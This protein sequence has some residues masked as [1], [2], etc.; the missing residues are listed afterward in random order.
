MPAISLPTGIGNAVCGVV[1][2]GHSSALGVGLK[3][4]LG[5][6]F[7]CTYPLTLAALCR[8]YFVYR[9]QDLMFPGIRYLFVFS[10]DDQVA[11]PEVVR[12][13]V[14]GIARRGISSDLRVLN[15][16]P[17]IDGVRLLSRTFIA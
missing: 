13:I 11:S 4:L 9:H 17:E 14:M 10:D 1:G 6:Y 3:A 7:T 12:S 15:I 8:I 16:Q 2:L 5:L